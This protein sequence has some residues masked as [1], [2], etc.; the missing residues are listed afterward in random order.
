MAKPYSGENTLTYL[1]TLMKTAL[2][3]KLDRGDVVNDLTSADPGKVLSAAQGKALAER[4]QNAGGGDMLKAVYDADG[5]GIADNAL[6]LEGRAASDFTT[7]ASLQ[8]YVTGLKGQPGGLVP[9]MEDGKI[10]SV[11]LPSYVDDVLEGYLSGGFFYAEETHET[12]LPGEGGKIYIDLPS[13]VSYRYSGSVYVPITSSDL[14][15]ISNQAVQAIWDAAGGED[16]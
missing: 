4:I 2:A 9:L 6:R 14:T 3:G 8:A 16:A 13:N 15:E 12:L 10:N 7:P 5:D 1:I 11:Y